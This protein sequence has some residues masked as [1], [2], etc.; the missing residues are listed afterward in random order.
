[1]GAT[2]LARDSSEDAPEQVAWTLP[3]MVLLIDSLSATSGS[4]AAD[5][6]DACLLFAS[7]HVDDAVVPGGQMLSIPSGPVEIPPGGRDASLRTQGPCSEEIERTS[8]LECADLATPVSSLVSFGAPLYSSLW[9]GLGNPGEPA[10]IKDIADAMRR[11][12]SPGVQK[13]K[14]TFFRPLTSLKVVGGPS[15]SLRKVE[16][17]IKAVL[18]DPPWHAMDIF[19]GSSDRS[20]DARIDQVKGLIRCLDESNAVI[21]AQEERERTL[22]AERR[23]EAPPDAGD[24]VAE[25]IQ[26]RDNEWQQKL[27]STEAALQEQLAQQMEEVVAASDT[28]VEELT[29]LLR[30]AETGRLADAAMLQERID[31]YA[32]KAAE[33]AVA[34]AEEVSAALERERHARA[35]WDRH[36]RGVQEGT[37]WSDHL[38]APLACEELANLKLQQDVGTSELVGVRAQLE[39]AEAMLKERDRQLKSHA[40]KIQQLEE[41]IAS[42]GKELAL[43]RQ[44]EAESL[45]LAEETDDGLRRQDVVLASKESQRVSLMEELASANGQL[46]VALK[47]S[48][49]L[50]RQLA[51]VSDELAAVRHAAGIEQTR[52]ERKMVASRGAELASVRAECA[53]NEG[54]V[55]L[56]A[57]LQESSS[58]RDHLPLETSRRCASSS[59]ERNSKSVRMLDGRAAATS[60]VSPRGGPKQR[61]AY[62]LERRE[63][64]EGTATRPKLAETVPATIR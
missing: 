64:K 6:A 42:T 35:V 40:D 22:L 46:L 38:Q 48:A 41:S 11:A 21:R 3:T 43:M 10:A 52:E 31:C 19:A 63:P 34:H 56:A 27:R 20:I 23:Q 7:V 37:E 24:A 60:G 55:K 14:L 17:D 1:M 62:L 58:R 18:E 9:L 32:A 2:A 29:A 26:A 12:R 36:G 39:A 4:E 25:L 49:S 54:K 16:P 33:A 61:S 51:A 8:L 5:D 53:A 28:R 13:V 45:R 30:T 47:E 15:A 57:A 59:A 50:K 44:K